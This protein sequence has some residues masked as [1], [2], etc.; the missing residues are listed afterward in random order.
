MSTRRWNPLKIT[1]VIFRVYH[2]QD[3]TSCGCGY[4]VSTL[5]IV[6][7]CELSVTILL[8]MFANLVWRVVIAL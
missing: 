8:N 7:L 6:Q 4:V 1:V 2:E 3:V 5:L